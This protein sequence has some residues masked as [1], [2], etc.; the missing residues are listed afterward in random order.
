MNRKIRIFLTI[1]F[2]GVSLSGCGRKIGVERYF[3]DKVAHLTESPKEP[4]AARPVED[5]RLAQI[6]LRKKPYKLSVA[7][8]PFEPLLKEKPAVAVPAAVKA[9]EIKE[10]DPL[11]GM[12]YLGMIKVVDETSV[13]LQTPKG[14]E[15]FKLNDEVNHLTLVE[16]NGE[17]VTFRKE[18]REYKL[19]RGVM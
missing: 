4:E 11:L 15:V 1:L 9:K 12:Q 19:K 5:V 3:K 7:A 8:D 17:F 16:I 6:I 14:K 18:S 13:L 10:E 2:L